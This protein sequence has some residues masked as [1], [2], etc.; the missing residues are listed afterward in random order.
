MCHIKSSLYQVF[1][2]TLFA[3]LPT[4]MFAGKIQCW[5]EMF[6]RLKKALGLREKICVV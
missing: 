4:E 6:D 5:T 3:R 1:D 2:Q